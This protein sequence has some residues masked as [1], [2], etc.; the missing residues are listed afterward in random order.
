M[1]PNGPPAC[2]RCG[3]ELP[4]AFDA[5]LY[6]PSCRRRASAFEMAR[7]PW[8]YVGPIRQAVHE[9][10]YH[11]R[12]RLGA[13][14]AQDMARCA[15]TLLPLE[16]IDGIVPVPAFWLKRRI[17]GFNPAEELARTLSGSLEKPLL[18]RALRQTRWT[19]T[20][21]RL[22]G[23]KRWSNVRA[24]FAARPREVAEHTVL[25][26]DDVFTSGATAQACALA[27]REA[28]ARNVYVLTAART[29]LS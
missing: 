23:R 12:W 29:P 28:G 18:R 27:L 11:H 16:D 26:V 2:V 15:Q 8:C 17:K 6:C 24:A 21:T 1:Q 9:F 3:V 13:W 5:V 20:Q 25:L 10:K 4:G 14:L 22:R 7:S 19:S